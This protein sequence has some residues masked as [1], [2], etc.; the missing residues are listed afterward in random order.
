VAASRSRLTSLHTAVASGGRE[1]FIRENILRDLASRA[2]M[3][4]DFLRQARQ[5]LQGALTR[6]RYGLTDEERVWWRAYASR[7][8]ALRTSSSPIRWPAGSHG[9]LAALPPISPLQVGADRDTHDPGVNGSRIL[10][11]RCK[12]LLRQSNGFAM[13]EHPGVALGE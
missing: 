7:P 10:C 9:V 8:P 1:T 11:S 12:P 13:E 3:D 4:P 6:L 2:A 5:D